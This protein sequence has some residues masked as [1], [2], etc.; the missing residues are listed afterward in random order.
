MPATALPPHF[1]FRLY[2]GVSDTLNVA[3]F[4]GYDKCGDEWQ[5]SV[6]VSSIFTSLKVGLYDFQ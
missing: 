1:Y 5:N 4:W 2:K 6:Y 3:A